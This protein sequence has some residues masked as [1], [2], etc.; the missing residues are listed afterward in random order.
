MI[1][2]HPNLF[3]RS[4]MSFAEKGKSEENVY[5]HR[6]DQKLL[7]ELKSSTGALNRDEEEPWNASL[8]GP[9]I[10]TTPNHPYFSNLLAARQAPLLPPEDPIRPVRFE[11]LL[12]SVWM[13]AKGDP[14]VP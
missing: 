7:T 1:A 10:T 13:L 8:D 11:P 14:N 6:E 2:S 4:C 3:S 9:T 12:R 5:F